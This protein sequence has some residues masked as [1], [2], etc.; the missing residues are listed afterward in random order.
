MQESDRYELE[1]FLE[2]D[3]IVKFGPG[4]VAISNL[5]P[6]SLIYKKH[7]N[8]IRKAILLMV[9]KNEELNNHT[10]NNLNILRK[11]IR[12]DAGGA[13]PQ[14]FLDKACIC[15]SHKKLRKCCGT[16]SRS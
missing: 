11:M 10:T 12:K 1:F 7:E 9:R 4:A 8:I 16:K 2:L 13:M 3:G 5:E 6:Y 14:S 15:G